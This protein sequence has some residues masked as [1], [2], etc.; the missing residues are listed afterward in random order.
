M[1]NPGLIVL[2]GNRLEDLFAAVSG[3]LREHPLAPLEEECFVVQSQGMGEWLK[4]QLATS[5]GVCAAVRVELP[6]RFL[7][8]AY[9]SVLGSAAVPPRS[10]LDKHPLTWRLMAMLPGLLAAA[11]AVVP[12]GAEDVYAPLR[13]FLQ[14]PGAMRRL[15][16]AQRLADLFDQYQVHRG[17]WLASWAQGQDV[18]NSLAPGLAKTPVP[19]ATEDLWQPALWREL[20]QLLPPEAAALS[21]PS[22]HAAF[23]RELQQVPPGAERP[24]GLP[25]RL[26]LF[27]TTHVPRQ[28]LEAI[29]ELAKVSQVVMAV[30]NPCRHYWADL[31]PDREM[32]QA[33]SRRHAPRPGMPGEGAS[34]AQL[35][36]HGHPL[37]AGWGRQSRDFIRLLD[38]YDS[39]AQS[40]VR[41]DDRRVD[42]FDEG[43]TQSGAPL[44]E[45]VQ[46]RI[47][48]LVPVGEN[49]P[50]PL[51]A[52]DRSIVF[53]I[54][55]NA[56]REVEVLHDQLLRL[57]AEG[58]A[59][60]P[61]APREVVVM[62][63]DVAAFE[64]AIRSVFGQH[65]R[66]D[67]PRRIPYRV[68]DLRDRGRSPLLVAVEWLLSARTERFT[69]SSLRAL[70]EVP[71][72]QARFGLA[73]GDMPLVARWLEDA[74][75]RWGLHS[76]QRE[77]LGLGEAGEQNTWEFGLQ[78]L[79]L[80]YAIGEGHLEAIEASTEVGG[81]EAALL[82]PVADLFA[83]IAQWWEQARVN[84]TPREWALVLRSLLQ[85]LFSASGEPDRV[86][87]LALDEAL[88][89]WLEACE[90]AGFIESVDLDVVREAWLE[91]V[92][93]PGVARRFHAG[94]VTF[95][96]LLPLRAV[97][98]K[99]VCLLGMND[100]D[101]PR[102]TL[103][104]DFDLMARPFMARPGDRSGRDDD[105][106][107]MLD[108]LLSSR[109]QWYVSWAGRSPRD[110]SEQPPS[111]LVAQLRD[112][113]A[114]V[115]GPAAVEERTTVHPLQPFSRRYFLAGN[116]QGSSTVFTY[117]R[118][119]RE[120][121]PAE[122]TVG[123]APGTTSVVE[124]MDGAAAAAEPVAV[125]PPTAEE[126]ARFLQNP[127]REYFKLRLGVAFPRLDENTP[128]EEPFVVGGLEGWGLMQDVLRAVEIRASREPP[129]VVSGSVGE[130]VKEE[131]ARL[132]RAGRLPLGAPGENLQLA[133]QTRLSSMV[134]CWVQARQ[135]GEYAQLL[136]SRL[137]NSKQKLKPEKLLGAWVELL[138]AGQTGQVSP[139]RLVAPDGT[140]LLKPP[141]AETCAAVLQGLVAARQVG[142]AGARPLPTAI[143]TG[144]AFLKDSDP[145]VAYEGNGY[146]QRGEVEDPCLAR[147]YPDYESLLEAG[148]SPVEDASSFAYWSQQLYGA[149]RTW[150]AEQAALEDYAG[151]EA[152][153]TGGE[154]DD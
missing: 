112:Y 102:R 132:Q 106:Q 128:D 111:V 40:R 11:A 47:R 4:M 42:L 26:V 53:H 66:T 150:A 108:A 46:A 126:L 144:I 87:L 104:T 122:G 19:L 137:C 67:D 73:P 20:L 95:C 121:Y 114:A 100:G 17:D 86:L 9:R 97:P 57:F 77:S 154:A 54:A 74:R 15:Q 1:V 70:L 89:T 78:R 90:D 7:W 63:P 109:Q 134:V 85:Q 51:A 135:A 29:A 44:L 147:L 68:A 110:D 103:R 131:L 116:S 61:L 25:R 65:E 152:G 50:P 124:N 81:L 13:R 94:G 2:H 129:G 56:Q 146:E 28:S 80:G 35:A 138:H 3:W 34:L 21:R 24:R 143:K 83:A 148:P 92:D 43:G 118:E 151:S 123:L 133:L 98:F 10:P 22:V 58:F 45:Q 91:T 69:Q 62:M 119:W 105:R 84:R 75:V 6:A 99:V 96:T 12:V 113:L 18:L 141:A 30:P 107:L 27:G 16:L 142:L 125:V 55:H 59:G 8:R 39:A 153:V 23:L 120:A 71:A 79:L 136:P 48:D 64:P 37:L 31:L 82:G 93:D 52:A 72:L 5:H 60:K 33:P 101:Y 49:P 140:L 36:P 14:E 115:W 149:F 32:L 130:W 139:Q 41:F 76:A 88:S 117:A 145:G 38:E 127:V